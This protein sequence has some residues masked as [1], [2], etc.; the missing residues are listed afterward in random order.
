M[1]SQTKRHVESL[2]GLR[3]LACLA[4]FGVHFQ[5]TTGLCGKI[6]PL[7][8]KTLLLNGN[9]GVCLFFVLSGFLLSLPFW[10]SAEGESGGGAQDQSSKTGGVGWVLSYALRR[11]GRILPAYFLCLTGL[12]L[13]DRSWAGPHGLSNVLLHYAFLHNFA[14][15][16]LYSISPPF[17]SIAVQA[18]FYL[19]FPLLILL[20][21]PLMARKPAAQVCLLVLAVGAYAGHVAVVQWVS[22]NA[23]AWHLP[24]NIV[25]PDGYVLEHTLLAHLSHFLIG[26]LAASVFVALRQTSTQ[27]PGQRID[28]SRRWLTSDLLFW[29][30]LLAIVL[31]LSVPDL[32]NRFQVPHGRYNLPYIPLLIAVMII[33]APHARLAGRILNFRPVLLLGVISY[34]VYVYH[35]PCMKVIARAM[36]FIHWTP[37]RNWVLFGIIS[38]ALT[39]VVSTISYLFVERPILRA[40]KRSAST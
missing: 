22:A 2:D 26:I 9:T 40:M 18:Q 25:R 4:V 17:W 35:L 38:L 8:I 11:I 28:G 15:Y 7:D 24:A 21:R 27:D 30:S 23:S 29:S 1:R 20:L 33:S 34:G 12:V 14:E 16:S 6:G 19:V 5:Q 36:Q 3:A 10:S 32:D 13:L 39:I 31:I 37:A